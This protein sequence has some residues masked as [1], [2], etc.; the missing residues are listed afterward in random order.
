MIK[1]YSYISKYSWRKHD[2]H[3][4][5]DSR[6]R[7]RIHPS[8]GGHLW[9]PRRDS[10]MI[11]RTI[12]S[13]SH[14][15][16]LF[17]RI[18]KPERDYLSRECVRNT[19]SIRYKQSVKKVRSS[20]ESNNTTRTYRTSPNKINPNPLIKKKTSVVYRRH[21]IAIRKVSY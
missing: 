14:S 15:L 6:L 21:A 17:V 2:R 12:I 16:S 19:R 13:W 3:T 11:R 10:F 18:T 7:T 4:C 9:R 5:T 20:L 8:L 1:V